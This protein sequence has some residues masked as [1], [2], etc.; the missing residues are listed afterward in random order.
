VQ[1]R[2]LISGDPRTGH[3]AYIGM[4]IAKRRARMPQ[5][6]TFQGGGAMLTHCLSRN[7]YHMTGDKKV[8]RL[9]VK[10]E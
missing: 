6:K 9:T 4:I 2:E 3:K 8:P 7:N 5:D 10:E 1:V